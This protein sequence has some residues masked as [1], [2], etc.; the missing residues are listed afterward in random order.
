MTGSCPGLKVQMI[1]QAV[2]VDELGCEWNPGA[3][4]PLL[5]TR[6]GAPF[7]TC[8][9]GPH[10]INLELIRR[11]LIRQ[12]QSPRLK[13]R[14][15][16]PF[17]IMQNGAAMPFHQLIG[18][19]GFS[20]ALRAVDNNCFHSDSLFG[21]VYGHAAALSC[22]ILFNLAAAHTTAP[23]RLAAC[24]Q[25]GGGRWV[26]GGLRIGCRGVAE[27][28]PVNIRPHLLTAHSASGRFFNRRTS[29]RRHSANTV[30]PLR[31]KNWR[32]T[33]GRSQIFSSV[34]LHIFK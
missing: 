32:Y 13:G 7:M 33:K 11:W 15:P 4:R 10:L 31:N 30:R 19:S 12:H 3:P 23:D 16:I 17:I 9:K 24:L 6:A 25:T 22:L 5:S 28:G 26:S 1:R 27:H 14:Y 8:L 20:A 29:V 21:S 2:Q 34:I 18:M